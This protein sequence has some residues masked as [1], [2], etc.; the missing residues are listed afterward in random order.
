MIQRKHFRACLQS[1]IDKPLRVEFSCA[2][3][4]K[5]LKVLEIIGIVA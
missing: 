5:I 1:W 3:E 4:V 2:E